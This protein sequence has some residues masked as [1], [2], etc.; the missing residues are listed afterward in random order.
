MLKVNVPSVAVIVPK[1]E[2]LK[3]TLALGIADFVSLE[4]TLPDITRLAPL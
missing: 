1:D 2:L 4:V 3:K